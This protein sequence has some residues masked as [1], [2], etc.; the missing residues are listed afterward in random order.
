MDHLHLAYTLP[1][2]GKVEEARAEIPILMQLKPTISVQEAVRYYAMWC[3]DKDF[4]D[5]MAKALRLAGLREERD[6]GQYKSLM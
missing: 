3:F 1:Y 4:R 5:K 6:P 2:V